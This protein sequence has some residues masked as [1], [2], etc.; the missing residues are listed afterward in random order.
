[1]GDTLA[2]DEATLF[3]YGDS[4]SITADPDFVLTRVTGHVLNVSQ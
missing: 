2:D 1:M 3:V 4:D